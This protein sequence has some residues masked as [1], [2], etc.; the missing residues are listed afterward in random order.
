[1]DITHDEYSD[2]ELEAILERDSLAGL[3]PPFS[4]RWVIYVDI[5]GFSQ[6]MFD[7]ERKIKLAHTYWDLAGGLMWGSRQHRTL[8]AAMTMTGQDRQEIQKEIAKRLKLWNT[9]LRV[10]SDSIF[11]FLDPSGLSG[12]SPSDMTLD[13][14]LVPDVASSLSRRLWESGFPH[15]G[16][17]S[18]GSCL[19]D[20]E[21]NVFLGEAIVRAVRWTERQEWFGISI[22]PSA[23]EFTKRDLVNAPFLVSAEV[24]VLERKE[25][26][27]VSQPAKII[28]C[29]PSYE[30]KDGNSIGQDLALDGFLTAAQ[31]CPADRSNVRDRYR[32]TA[33]IWREYFRADL[34]MRRSSEL[35]A[36]ANG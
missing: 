20:A 27:V 11:V 1:M 6:V 32:A 2:S 10:F 19:C 16:G 23:E 35:E 4:E 33:R 29:F 30:R 25:G 9:R 3:P 36:I 21:R 28:S 7:A 22:D 24:P 13:G 17:V 31:T 5:E 15:K 8:H 12:R 18:Y 26:P 14:N 34:G